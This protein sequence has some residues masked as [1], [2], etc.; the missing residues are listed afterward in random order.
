MATG[1]VQVNAGWWP[2]VVWTVTSGLIVASIWIEVARRQADT[3]TPPAA[4]KLAIVG[5]RQRRVGAV[6][7][8]AS[9]F[10]SRASVRSRIDEIRI[11]GSPVVLVGGGGVGKS[12]LAAY[13][14]DHAIRSGTDLV[15]WVD[16]TQSV[17]I[18][19]TYAEAAARVDVGTANDDVGANAAAFLDWMAT[20]DRSWLVV[21]DD[22]V[23]L[24]GLGSWW[25]ISH[26]GTGWVLATTRRREAVLSGG[27]RSMVEVDVYTGDESVAY[28]RDRL[29]GA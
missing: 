1:A 5:A 16:A 12:Q 23:D 13:Y 26:T 3:A 27:G 18:L 29:V 9:A 22:I 20:T 28:L 15:L 6:P 10:R 7:A 8:L 11:G 17:T 19:A 24:D 21:L 25:P 14:A 4:T 2:P